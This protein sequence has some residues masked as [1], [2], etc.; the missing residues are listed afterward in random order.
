M[1]KIFKD[2]V[3]SFRISE[4]GFSSRKLTAF[5]IVVLVIIIHA[6]WLMLGNLA[7]LE[8]VLTIDYAFISALFG[9]T[10]FQSLKTFG[11]EID[12][13]TTEPEKDKET[14]VK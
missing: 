13:K 11:K 7:Q 10:T 9:M 2:L 6:K 1:K 5:V 14:E 4:T 12:D 8:M 3:D